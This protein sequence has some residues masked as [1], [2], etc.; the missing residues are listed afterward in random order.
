[1]TLRPTSL[2]LV[3]F[4]RGWLQ[5]HSPRD[6]LER[7]DAS[8]GDGLLL[9]WGDDPAGIYA[10]LDHAHR[11]GRP[12]LPA[13][14]AP[15]RPQANGG[16]GGPEKI[17][18]FARSDGAL[19]SLFT[20]FR[21]S[22]DELDGVSRADE[23]LALLGVPGDVVRGIEAP[24]ARCLQ[25]RAR[26]WIDRLGAD[27]VVLAVLSGSGD[28]LQGLAV[29]WG[30]PWIRLLDADAVEEE[31]RPAGEGPDAV[32]TP[33]LWTDFQLDREHRLPDEQDIP[34]LGDLL[35]R[36]SL[37]RERRRLQSMPPAWQ[38]TV[39]AELRHLHAWHLGPLLRRA[40]ALI[41]TMMPVPGVRVVPPLPRVGGL[42][43][44]LL[45]LSDRRPAVIGRPP[46]PQQ[47]S[48]H[49]MRA[50]QN[51]DRNLVVEVDPVAWP[52]LHGR[53]VGWLDS[54]YLAVCSEPPRA[55]GRRLC[56]S[57]RPLWTRRPLV[58]GRDGIPQMKLPLAD[59]RALGWFEV[60]LL[61][62]ATPDAPSASERTARSRDAG[63]LHALSDASGQAVLQLE[64]GLQQQDTA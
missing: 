61:A 52:R 31:P 15:A 32:G 26:K 46:D 5:L 59:R 28:P 12:L 25:D 27:R 2:C 38:A 19:S 40:G 22:G 43:S 30:L 44:W 7:I 57:G 53:L 14:W 13:R 17:L 33:L 10:L 36:G 23:P 6:L 11:Q 54:G 37:L 60:E 4:D 56:F 58:R 45:G 47:S 24:G 29:R 55:V 50:L 64:L 63:T 21:L 16:F 20:A 51:W 3:R 35:R 49:L 48:S 9:E 62:T 8:G 41:Q 39:D 1:M 34:L 18:W 42:C